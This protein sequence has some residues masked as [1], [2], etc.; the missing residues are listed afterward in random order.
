M[1]TPSRSKREQDS[2]D[3][4][5]TLD[6]EDDPLTV[7][8]RERGY[9]DA[10]IDPTGVTGAG[11]TV[12]VETIQKNELDGNET[13]IRTSRQRR[14][15]PGCHRT[16]KSCRPG[17]GSARSTSHSTATIV[18]PQPADEEMT[19]R[20]RAA[21]RAD[22]L[23]MAYA[24]VLTIDTRGD[25]VTLTGT[26][27]NIADLEAVLGVAAGVEGINEVADELEIEA[28]LG[29]SPSRRWVAARP[30]SSGGRSDAGVEP[31]DI[32]FGA[33]PGSLA[34]CEG[35]VAL[36]VELDRGVAASARHRGR[37]TLR[38]SRWH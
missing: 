1:T 23:A 25:V 15:C 28:D 13:S 22:A 30:H 31:G 2:P 11:D 6:D 26:V 3:D 36:G 19:A 5:A 17:P 38:D 33:E 10:Q 37:P 32:G 4:A 24:D 29:R 35:R 27:A 21:L 20:V 9:L 8:E 16:I 7:T 14:A 34:L 12:S 18:L